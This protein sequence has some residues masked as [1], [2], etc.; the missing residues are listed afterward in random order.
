LALLLDWRGYRDRQD[1]LD[2]NK[3]IRHA[4][5]AHWR[6]TVWAALRTT[7][8]PTEVVVAHVLSHLHA[9]A[10]DDLFVGQLD[11]TR[12][13]SV[14][15]IRLPDSDEPAPH[16]NSVSRDADD[17][18]LDSDYDEYPPYDYTPSGSEGAD[19]DESSV[20]GVDESEDDSDDAGLPDAKRV[21][22]GE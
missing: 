2:R 7:P 13:A 14:L 12:A 6:R 11:F 10:D 4:A 17:G 15:G 5:V 20:D 3:K 21:K 1:Y 22:E 9:E 19:E 16:S 18:M 8:L